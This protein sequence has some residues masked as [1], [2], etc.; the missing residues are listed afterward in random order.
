MFY[1]I[2]CHSNR[3]DGSSTPG[4]IVEYARSFLDGIAITDHDEIK[5]SLE[6]LKY[7]SP[8]F[9]VIPGLEVSSR[10]GHILA[11]YVDEII[12]KGLAAKETVH[13]IHARGGLAVAA[14]PYDSF[15]RGVGD[16]I[17]KLDFDAVEV[18][19]GHTLKST[20]DPHKVC[21][22][23]GMP[24]VG[25]SDAHLLREIGSVKNEFDGDFRKALLSAMIGIKSRHA[26][27]LMMNNIL[28]IGRHKI[29]KISKR[30]I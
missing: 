26:T 30:W 8:D 28:S 27:A 21:E 18:V 24:M 17:A 15:R 25:G 2:H 29:E 4:E 22:E 23:I 20:K 13:R 5:G 16:L 19:N 3:S 1:E 10:E 7:A 14:H 6:A 11:L 9:E 12:P